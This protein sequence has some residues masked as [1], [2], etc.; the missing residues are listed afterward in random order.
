MCAVFGASAAHANL[1]DAAAYHAAG[2]SGVPADV[3]LTITRLE[4]GRGPDAEPWPWAVN[5]A[6]QGT[7]FG[8]EDD[9]RSFV[10]SKI[11]TGT[12]N[13]DIGC[14]QINYR[15]HADG[16]RSLDAMFNPETNAEYAAEFLTRLYREFGTWS[17][18][19]AAY[20]SRT[21]EFA[22]KYRARFEEYRSGIVTALPSQPTPVVRKVAHAAKANTPRRG[23]L[24]LAE[25]A[26]KPFINIGRLK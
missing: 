11:K 23:S 7:W 25:T 21:P 15:W 17:D 1:C 14:F 24:F 9:A 5:Q 13:I 16:F 19:A 4:T 26:T 22:E 12:T 10:F 6:G 3:L 2:Q 20:H 8:S 18:A